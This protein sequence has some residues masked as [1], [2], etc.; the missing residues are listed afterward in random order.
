MSHRLLVS[1]LCLLFAAPQSSAQESA[2]AAGASGETVITV[3]VP[4]QTATAEVELVLP[5][6]VPRVSVREHRDRRAPV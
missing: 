2:Y 1:L 3:P 6:G 4:G 5:R